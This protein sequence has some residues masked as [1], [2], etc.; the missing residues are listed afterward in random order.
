MKMKIL[1]WKFKRHWKVKEKKRKEKQN[2]TLI[3]SCQ[4]LLHLL[5]LLFL[6]NLLHL[7]NQVGLF[8]SLQFFLFFSTC[9]LWFYH[10][11][12]DEESIMAFISKTTL[13]G[14]LP[15][16]KMRT[17]EKQIGTWIKWISFLALLFSCSYSLRIWQWDDWLLLP[18]LCQIKLISFCFC[19]LLNSSS[20]SHHDLQTSE[21][22]EDCSLAEGFDGWTCQRKNG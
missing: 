19:L 6:L 14:V 21:Q 11:V 2:F 1:I 13:V 16:D 5:H 20:S 8:L 7:L 9:F 18:F 17:K 15:G 4:H 12:R 10:L 3:F 22:W